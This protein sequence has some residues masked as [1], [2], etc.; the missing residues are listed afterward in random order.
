VLPDLLAVCVTVA[1]DVVDGELDLGRAAARTRLAV[2]RECGRVVASS[3]LRIRPSM[4][5]AVP[6][7]VDP[8]LLIGSDPPAQHAASSGGA[9][10]VG[11]AVDAGGHQVD[12]RILS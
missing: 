7:K 12:L 11:V 2:V 9:R 4:S 8:I 3:A 1:V 10:R 6:L 5:G